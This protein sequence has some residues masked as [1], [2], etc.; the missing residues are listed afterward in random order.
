METKSDYQTGSVAINGFAPVEYQY[1][2]DG[3]TLYL[4]RYLDFSLTAQILLDI[5]ERFRKDHGTGADHHLNRIRKI[6]F[7]TA[8]G[9]V[10]GTAEITLSSMSETGPAD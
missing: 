5:I 9:E 1:R 7:E 3:D 8:G 2:V 10:D 6:V 4:R